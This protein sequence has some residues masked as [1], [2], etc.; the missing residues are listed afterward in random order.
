MR[1]VLA[2]PVVN[3]GWSEWSD[4]SEC[5]VSCGRGQ[6]FRDR[7]C[8]NPPPSPGGAYCEG[9]KVQQVQECNPVCGGTFGV[10]KGVWGSQEGLTGQ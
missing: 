2:A 6:Q 3:G 5:S 8:T 7:D 10:L 9:T 1:F 4:W